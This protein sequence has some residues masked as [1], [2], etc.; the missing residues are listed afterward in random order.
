MKNGK[1]ADIAVG[2]GVCSSCDKVIDCAKDGPGDAYNKS[3]KKG[4]AVSSVGKA[5]RK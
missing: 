1:S 5:P 4:K 2:A 3:F